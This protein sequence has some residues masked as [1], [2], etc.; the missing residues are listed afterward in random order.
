MRTFAKSSARIACLLAAVG[1]LLTVSV[2]EIHR[3]RLGVI[4]A[5]AAVEGASV[6]LL[7]QMGGRG[8]AAKGP[9]DD[10]DGLADLHTLGYEPHYV[11]GAFQFEQRGCAGALDAAWDYAVLLCDADTDLYALTSMI[12]RRQVCYRTLCNVNQM[13]WFGRVLWV[14]V[15]D[16]GMLA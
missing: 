12:L 8:G 1:G 2:P 15:A 13:L 3:G 6:H 11:D 5:G 14:V 4:L 9:A 7:W 16:H 10:I